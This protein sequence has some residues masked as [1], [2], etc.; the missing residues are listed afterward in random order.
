MSSERLA[1]LSPEK[2]ALL[3]KLL[4]RK[5]DTGLRRQ[6]R[7]GGSFPLSF[8]QYR[9]WFL[10]QMLPGNPFFNECYGTRFELPV[11]VVALEGA[12]NEIVRRH[13]ALRTTFPVVGGEPVQVIT[14]NLHVPL[15]VI[16]LKHLPVDER[17]REARRLAGEEAQRTIDISKGPLLHTTLLQLGPSDHIF[18]VNFHHIIYDGWSTHV[19]AHEVETLYT[20]YVMGQ[21]SP[22]PELPIQYADFAVWQRRSLKGAGLKDQLDYWKKQ[23]A[24]LPVLNLPLDRP[25]PA[26]QS[27]RGAH[28]HSEISSEVY[29][30][31]RELSQ[32]E[33]VTMFMV[34]MAA[35]KILL[36]HYTEQDDIVLGVPI[37]NRSR[38]ELEKLIGFFVNILVMRTD[39]S[40]NPTFR[41]VL[42]RVRKVSLEA[43]AHQ[44][45]PFE[46]LV[47]ELHPDREAGRSPLFQ[48]AFQVFNVPPTT[49]KMAAGSDLQLETGITKFDIRID[50]WDNQQGLSAMFEY[51]TDLFDA[52][53]ITR[54]I[55]HY[56]T[57]LERIGA[58]P[59][60]PIS[61]LSLLSTQERHQLL[62]EWNQTQKEYSRSK[63]VTQVFEA[64]AAL[65]PDAAAVVCGGEELSYGEL[66]R[67]ANQLA[68]YLR[69]HGVGPES[70]VAV[71]MER[72]LGMVVGLLG[73]LKAGGAY[74]PLDPAYPE[75]RLA[76][77][78]KDAQAKLLLTKQ[79]LR[80]KFS[81]AGTTII[82]LDTEGHKFVGAN[83]SNPSSETLPEH[84][85]YV[86]YTSGST[87]RPKGVEIQHDALM[88]LV[89]WHQSVYNVTFADRATQLAG[90]GFDASVWELWPYLSAGASIHIPD[91]ATVNVPSNLLEW[92]AR[93]QITICFL[94]TPLAEAVLKESLPANLRL[95]CL[96]TGGDKL[97]GSPRKALPFSYFNHYGP[98]ENTV[99]ATYAPVHGSGQTGTAPPIGRPINNV[100]AYVLNSQ[101]HPVP[102]GVPGELY[103]GGASL[104][105][106][107]LN[108]PALTAERFIPHPFGKRPGERLYRTG[109]SVK[110][111]PDGNLEFLGRVDQQVKVRG[112]RIELGEI[113]TTLRQHPAVRDAVAVVREDAYG[114]KR[115]VAYVVQES[116]AQR[117]ESALST[118]AV[119]QWQSIYDKVVYKQ[120][121]EEQPSQTDPTFNITGWRSTYTGQTI[122]AQE[123]REQVE[124][125]AGRI[126]RLRPE[127]VL[128]VGC[129]TGLL[130]FKIA[131]H[132]MHYVATD[133][134]EVVLEHVKTQLTK[135]ALA[136]VKLIQAA[137]DDFQ[138]VEGEKFD[139][140]I[141]NSVV[142]YFPNIDYLL[143]VLEGALRVVS[144]GGRIFL[145]DMR[146]LPLLQ[147][148][149][150]SLAL[151]QAAPSLTTKELTQRIQKRMTQEKELLI[152]PT[153]FTA[154]KK[155]LPQ[156]S[157]V[158]V[159]LKRGW[160]HNEL[161]CYRYDVMLQVEGDAN[162]RPEPSC[163]GWEQERLSLSALRELLKDQ[164]P[165]MLSIT[166]VPN[167][168]LQPDFKA[169][170]LLSGMECPATVEGLGQA[171]ENDRDSGVEPEALWALGQELGYEVCI[172]WLASGASGKYD[173]LLKRSGVSK[174]NELLDFSPNETS[175]YRPWSDYANDPLQAE[176]TDKLLPVLR[177]LLQKRLPTYM[178]P[179]SM[180]LL[181]SLPLT[182]NG[183]LDRRA[184]PDPG[185]DRP[186]VAG[187]FVPP[188]TEIEKTVAHIW[189]EV[190]GVEKVGLH[191]NFFDL[192]GH[193]LLLVQ[194]HTKLRKT[195]KTE[196]SIIDLFSLP[197]VTS[198]VKTL[199][200]EVGDS[201]LLK[202]IDEL[203]RMQ[204]TL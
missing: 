190:L 77:M 53:T 128:E 18:L 111:R 177:V 88:N 80:H 1:Q 89:S 109:D 62:S 99:V 87:G 172:G 71:C 13:E 42:K 171:L 156:I 86:I 7:D 74:V 26:Q 178:M 193:S 199:G 194:L 85:A 125:T 179:S 161:T 97:Q 73:I 4:K 137:A 126:L 9:I 24:D 47:E 124:G 204:H 64:Q 16:S 17:E 142:Q 60:L 58:N 187:S 8:G 200:L 180:L 166:G 43:Y 129:G 170:E 22:L 186:E 31:L 66:N 30:P 11:N 69:Q 168:R 201:P 55:G 165:D 103:I 158:Q 78:I 184:L 116:E 40:G 159:Q 54:M 108:H 20:A 145:G 160:H 65:T 91:Q 202:G 52:T 155:H 140:V 175:T 28:Q 174:S 133:F 154:L 41:E 134:S 84:L 29:L 104:A 163:L 113:E 56:Q 119:S 25:R 19:F 195:F 110:F 46:K 143:R 115:L 39:L 138:N 68:H 10:E 15:A 95:R 59:D 176:F 162:S 189:Q 44:D 90:P 93:E 173:L 157:R 107:Y 192:G 94:P 101:L 144:P 149:H 82:C 5:S 33:G 6:P 32:R 102:A 182:P 23:L 130:L 196:L 191:D 81:E 164:T 183:K 203:P 123:M 114:E 169:L 83:D 48:V 198:L 117:S 112:F 49:G 27:Y 38:P 197:T 118:A 34:M 67:R 127:R 36:H 106:G 120:V 151:H 152:A 132:T 153:F 70:L 147:M 72:S 167:G 139:T 185:H 21:K 14:P 131:P 146:S 57:L 76:F 135:S 181:D 61:Q 121:M 148:L 75:Q 37:A 3:L 141:M 105:R 188:Q 79:A 12:V 136:Q 98:T 2:R 96:L 45:I 100:E 51:S 63:T 150:T 92:L 50:L 35:Y 122:P